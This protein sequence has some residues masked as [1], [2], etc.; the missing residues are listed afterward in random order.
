MFTTKLR[1]SLILACLWF[2]FPRQTGAAPTTPVISEFMAA[3]GVT[4][5]DEDKEASDWIEI[6]N[7]TAAR[8]NM[9]GWYLTDDASAPTKWRFP[10][11]F[12]EPG[13]YLVVFA[14][15]KNRTGPGNL[16]TN[17]RLGAAGDYLALIQPDQKTAATEFAP[18]FPKQ[19][20]DIAYG[21]P[22]AGATRDLLA[23]ASPMILV[24]LAAGDL[25][26]DW[27][28]PEAIPSAKW[29][30]VTAFAI[31]YD[32]TPAGPGADVNLARAGVAAQSTTGFGLAAANGNDGNSSTFTH[33][34]SN[35]NASAWWVDL[36][37]VFEIRRVVLRNRD[38]CCASRLR[39]ITVD[40]LAADG[41]TVL[42]TSGLLNPENILASPA[43]ITV[44][45]F[46]LNVGA[47]PARTV[48]V[49][50]T[51][52][53]DLSGSGGVGN[54]DE[55][56]VLSLGEVEV[57]G[58]DSTSYGSFIRADLSDTMK[59]R[60]SSVFVRAPFVLDSPEAVRS[61][62]LRLLYDDGVT[63]WLNGQ[64]VASFN[65]PGSAAWNGVALSKRTKAAGMQPEIVDLEP[66]RAAWR[67]GTNWL[68]FQGL[69]SAAG[70]SEFLLDAKLLA[71]TGGNDFYAYLDHPTPGAANAKNWDLGRVADTKFG[72]DRG[73][74]NAPFDLTITTATV[75]AEVR[76]TLD[77]S[78]PDP[79]RSALYTGPLRIDRTTVVRAAGFKPNY[80]QTD[81]DTYTYLFLSDIV[82]QAT[83]PAG[84]PATWAGTPA[85]Y[86][87]DPRITKAAAYTN[88]MK[89]S[90]QALPSLAITTPQDNLFGTSRGIYA[91]P[92]SNGPT[93]ERP[94]SLEW[95]KPDGTADF[96]IDCG[97]R[98]QGGYFRQRNITQKHS[99]RLLFKTDYGPG[100]LTQD[101][102]HE[103]GVTREF[104][105]LVLRAGAND[106]Y[107]WDAAKDTEQFARDEFGRR[108]L[109]A[110]GQRTGSGMFVHVYLNGLYW[111]VYNLVERPAE[112]F[113]V[114]YFGGA[115][116]DWDAINAGDVKNG[117]LDAW[118]AFI[119]G[120][121]SAVTLADY[122]KLK[123]LNAD[124]SR[125]PA[126]PVYLES[127]NYIDYML[128]NIWGGN[129]DWPNKNF[130]FGRHRGGLAGG[131]KF[132]LW[133]F[134][135][136]M[137]NNRDRSPLNM[138]SPRAGITSSWVGE[139]HDRL[140]ALSEY[141][142]E[143]ADRVQKHLFGSGALT[144]ASLIARYRAITDPL[145]P[146]I[147]AETARW[148]DDQFSPPQDLVK[149]Q[150]ERDWLVGTYLPQRTAVVL[151]Q[152]K[153]KGLFPATA[154]PAFTP[155]GGAVSSA[156]PV[157]ISTTAT[158]LYYTTDG[159]DPRLVGGAVNPNAVKFA[160]TGT[161][162]HLADPLA[163]KG[164]IRLKARA[165]QGTDWSPLSDAL[166]TPD[167]VPATSN[168]VV[169]AEF[170]Y[171]PADAATPAEL[172]VSRNRDDYEFI[173]IMNIAAQAVDLTGVRFTAGVL[174][175]F[176]AGTRLEAGERL[177]VVSRRAAF[178]AR[179]GTKIRVA[180]EYDG[181]LDN[182]GE[183][184]AL[185]DATGRDIRRFYYRDNV[186]WPQGANRNG[187]SLVLSRPAT[188]PDHTDPAQWRSSSQPGG[189]PG[190]S[191]ASR[192]TG[193]P[194]AD[195]DGNGQADLLDYALGAAL[196]A[197]GIGLELGTVTVDT[198]GKTSQHLVIT[199]P[200]NLAAEDAPV[201]LELAA[202]PAGPWRRGPGLFTLVGEERLPNGLARQTLRLTDPIAPDSAAFVRM[203]VLLQP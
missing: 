30:Q 162:T 85:D 55:D 9:D 151:A 188:N 197:P 203:S 94:I 35:D 99:L 144:P 143:F 196:K 92:E 5:L 82:T 7:P 160:F 172:A 74:Y 123:G 68:A 62:R 19:E 73:V 167:V 127:E 148:G 136:T 89:A 14:S 131:F 109:L 199:H 104:D 194:N 182:G 202:S 129:W 159:T 122:Q 84:F 146:A 31:G 116:E 134:E 164:P 119:T 101:I 87:M 10:E 154:A 96:Q 152:L 11:R 61:L 76:Y 147:I 171:R 187:Y 120:V 98:I 192:F 80:R 102:F 15:A 161:G 52:D 117:S 107:A 38:S 103:F 64:Q 125:N 45:L 128:V 170:C 75:G 78:L 179:Y 2:A 18:K 166:F 145:E 150:K 81:V 28:K 100:R 132:Y 77:G 193:T 121:R 165:R 36:G 83:T 110:M 47:I 105:T 39:D 114:S 186:P 177:V 108:T 70:D 124:G 63:V 60:N 112:D 173:E 66:F 67:T 41:R 32:V 59:G 40:L 183:E 48:R 12:I 133:D 168:Q 153:S 158:E 58:V 43:S 135:N 184:I 1:L 79:V 149:W 118:N 29:K 157:Q 163:V 25:L 20:T 189:T 54:A 37:A 139:P 90:L 200:R 95:I 17:F 181:T 142:I 156:V 33:T 178:E 26:A 126:Y 71:E 141:K 191:D 4:L 57:Y 34:D 185:T 198:N 111:G 65:A 115:P 27:A 174:Y 176:P 16:H 49:S 180:G 72:T 6:Q 23:G 195:A 8:V 97:L 130:W 175:N 201:I 155:A 24:P 50:R 53:P 93:W 42:W 91:N 88:R 46:D 56:N 44:D 86:A 169:I 113:S 51:P 13:G 190:G 22:A 137:G 138:V 69:N 106:G 140:K 21:I 3:N